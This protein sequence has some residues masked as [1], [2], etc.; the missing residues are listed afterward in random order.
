MTIIFQVVPKI[1]TRKGIRFNALATWEWQLSQHILCILPR[2]TSLA[3]A[4]ASSHRSAPPGRVPDSTSPEQ[5]AG[6]EGATAWGSDL[7]CFTCVFSTSEKIPWKTGEVTPWIPPL[8]PALLR[9][10]QDEIRS[11]AQP[12]NFTFVPILA[13]MKPGSLTASLLVPSFFW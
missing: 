8:D 11:T 13:I 2:Y 10:I 12:I 7:Y 3:S 1:G 9:W 6:E 4:M 5:E